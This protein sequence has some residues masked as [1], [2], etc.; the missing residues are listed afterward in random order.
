ML[1]S[2][3][4]HGEGRMETETF[5]FSCEIR[6]VNNRFLRIS[7]KINEQIA[8]LQAGLE[9]KVREAISRGSLSVI[10]RFDPVTATDFYHLDLQVLDKYREDLSRY[11]EDKGLNDSIQLK[12][13][14]PLPGVAQS[15]ETAIPDR[16][17]LKA[18]AHSCLKEAIQTLTQMRDLEGKNLY[19]E[20]KLR[21]NLLSEQLDKIRE[22]AP[23]GIQEY[24]KRLEDRVNQA[25][26]RHKV[27]LAPEDLIKEVALLSERSDISEE[28]HRLDSHLGQF[29]N[30]LEDEGP[31]G[32]KLEFII[33]EMFREANTMASKSIHPELNRLL[34]DTK[35]ELDRLKEQVQNVE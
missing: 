34:V 29:E 35:T 32:R 20:F 5:V 28:I 11:I 15:D 33:Q 18:A 19:E 1:R 2:M 6:S 4:G 9:D 25:L 3:T 14:L 8:F 26:T 22:L 13:L 31:C 27:T 30:C 23:L 10:V 17:E 24:Q 12:D 21:K 16:E 7:T